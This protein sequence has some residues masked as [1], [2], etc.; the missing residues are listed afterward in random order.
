[1]FEL[2][3]LLRVGPFDV[4]SGF[5]PIPGFKTKDAEAA[6][7]NYEGARSKI[8]PNDEKKTI[9]IRMSQATYNYVEFRLQFLENPSHELDDGG[10]TVFG[11]ARTLD[12]ET[13]VQRRRFVFVGGTKPE[14]AGRK[15]KKGQC[16]HALGMPRLNF[17][18]VSWRV[19]CSKNRVPSVPNCSERYPDV[20]EWGLPYEIVVIADYG[21]S[22]KCETD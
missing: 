4:T 17:S 20:L 2:H 16:M 13:V 12:G 7:Q 19:A 3:P 21:G 6:F 10:F 15:L 1:V 14:I 8:T 18:L 11:R 9:R 5:H 22:R